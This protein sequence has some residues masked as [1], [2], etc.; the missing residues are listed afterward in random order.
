MRCLSYVLGDLMYSRSQ[1]VRSLS[2][3]TVELNFQSKS[4]IPIIQINPIAM[5]SYYALS[6]L[7]VI[8]PGLTLLGQDSLVFKNN[9]F[10]AGEIKGMDRGVLTIETDYSKSDF[11]IEWSG[12]KEIF[13]KTQ[14]LITLTDGN[15]ITGTLSSADS[16]NVIVQ[17]PDGKTSQRSLNDLVVLKQISDKFLDRVYA[18]ISVGYSLTRAQTLQQLSMRSN[19]GYLTERWSAGISYNTFKSSQDDVVDIK[20][21]DGGINFN[22]FLPKDWYIP[23]SVS[24]LSNTEQKIDLRLLGKAGVGKYV[25]HKNDAYWGFSGG[26]N[27]NYED[28]D[29]ETDSRTS[30]EAFIGT[31]LNLFDIGDLSLFTRATAYPSLTESGRFRADFNFD[32][33]YDLPYDFFV[34]LGMTYNY[35]NRPVEGAPEGD[36]IFQTT[37]GWSW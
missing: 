21:K 19:V 14:F 2:I 17:D 34:Q 5:R 30:W 26:A 16:A 3:A 25:I 27:V 20:R 32:M 31:E 35:D 24:Y 6:F 22:Y 37:F 11:T 12:I 13:T 29:D 33:K 1:G 15:R 28:F 18:S 8:F 10:V 23:I 9:D 4:I 36:Y 7:L